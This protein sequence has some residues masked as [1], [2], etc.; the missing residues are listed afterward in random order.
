MMKTRYRIVK[1][2]TNIIDTTSNTVDESDVM[3]RI[4]YST[5]LDQWFGRWRNMDNMCFEN[6]EYA[7]VSLEH[8][9]K[10]HKIKT[11]DMH[12]VVYTTEE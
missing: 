9:I 4:Q 5:W 10:R 1:E 2:W 6:L 3:Y 8:H 7:K 11:V 12:Q